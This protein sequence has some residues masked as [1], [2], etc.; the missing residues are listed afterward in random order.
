[1]SRLLVV[2][3]SFALRFAM[4]NFFEDRGYAVD[5]AADLESARQCLVHRSY[6]A[7]ILDWSLTP[8]GSEGAELLRLLKRVRKRKPFVVVL[9]ALISAAVEQQARDLGADRV[10]WKPAELNALAQLLPPPKPVRKRRDP[11]RPRS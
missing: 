11:K 6:A 5:E 10:L 4:R 2:D 3:D 1:M 9:T 8:E 7:V